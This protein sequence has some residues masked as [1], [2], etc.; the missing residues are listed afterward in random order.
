[1]AM[2]QHIRNPIEW[3]WDSLKQT[4]RAMG[5]AGQTME[6][7]W[8]GRDRTVP[9]VQHITATHLREVRALVPPHRALP[10]HRRAAGRAAAGVALAA[11]VGREH[12]LA[13]RERA[14][15]VHRLRLGDR[16]RGV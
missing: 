15:L 16:P 3:G 13:G 4:G 7:A 14:R 11:A 12:L 8:E 2:Q 6:G 1:M 5:S 9:A 10:G